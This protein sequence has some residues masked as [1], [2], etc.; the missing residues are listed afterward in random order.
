M[1]DE[2]ILVAVEE[3]VA[4]LTL[5]RPEVMNALAG[6]T[7]RHM[8]GSL[9]ELADRGDVRVVVITGNG[10]AFCTGADLGDPEIALDG[11][12][13][14]RPAK[15]AALMRD[16]INPLMVELQNFPRPTIAAVN[17]PAVGGGIGV[18]L[19]ADIVIASDAAYFM[20]VFTPKLGLVPDMGVTW[21][22]ERLV[23]RARARGLAVLG[24]RLSATSAA[25]WGLIWKAVSAAE[26]DAEVASTA[27]RIADA[28][29]LAVKAVRKVLDAAP[30]NGF[31]Q[32]LDLE[33]DVQCDLVGTADAQDAVLAFREKRQP[34]FTGR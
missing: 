28:P 33:C 2:A 15:L 22:M 13:E 6:S 17:G 12:L 1:S 5:N 24:D 21:H 30:E 4:T 16:Q 34:R 27:R 19:A 32:Q 10:R 18:A 8:R 9:K 20:Q 25:E 11:E 14:D 23:G 26:F 7:I 29:P 3:G 31:A